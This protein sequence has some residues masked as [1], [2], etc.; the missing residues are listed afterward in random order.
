MKISFKDKIKRLLQIFIKIYV[1][2]CSQPNVNA[3]WTIMS[4]FSPLFKRESQS[5][6]GT[7]NSYWQVS[8]KINSL[9]KFFSPC[10]SFNNPHPHKHTIGRLNNAVWLSNLNEITGLLEKFIIFRKSF[11]EMK[12][13]I[14]KPVEK[15]CKVQWY[16]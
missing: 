7:Y 9:T 1:S 10:F 15:F 2:F 5:C 11:Q 3:P 14:D 8:W 6:C 16:T 4:K 13:D 12:L